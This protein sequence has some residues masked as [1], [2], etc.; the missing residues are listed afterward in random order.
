[1]RTIVDTSLV[2]VKSNEAN[3]EKIG[4]CFHQYS[5]DAIKVLNRVCKKFQ[6]TVASL[7]D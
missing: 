6:N 5:K 7:K 4:I 2:S 3:L 1:M